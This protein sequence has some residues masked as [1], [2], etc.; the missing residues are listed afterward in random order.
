MSET[1]FFEESTHLQSGISAHTLSLLRELAPYTIKDIELIQ[2]PQEINTKGVE[3]TNQEN[4][5][6][7]DRHS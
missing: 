7:N 4:L 1:L 3:S 6:E 5:S 2:D